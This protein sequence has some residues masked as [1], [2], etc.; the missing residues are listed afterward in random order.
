MTSSLEWRGAK[1]LFQNF[2]N[3]SL[4]YLLRHLPLTYSP[5]THM[6]TPFAM[7]Y[8]AL[9]LYHVS[10]RTQAILRKYKKNIM[11]AINEHH[12]L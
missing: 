9:S 11:N 12:L 3:L 5:R 1:F 4:T 7:T 10:K 8:I 2:I 6:C